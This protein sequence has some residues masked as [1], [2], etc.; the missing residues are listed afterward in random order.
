VLPIGGLKEKIL[1]AHRAG[2]KRAIVPEKNRHDLEEV[3]KDV[4]ADLDMVFVGR[5]SQVV[6]AALETVPTPRVP[7]APPLGAPPGMI[8]SA[9]S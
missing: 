3:P 1:A 5:M 2:I 7:L 8:A 6:E 9:P 4:L